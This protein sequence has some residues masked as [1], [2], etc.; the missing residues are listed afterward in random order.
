MKL[1]PKYPNG[2][3]QCYVCHEKQNITM[4]LE[5]YSTKR[6]HEQGK[7]LMPHATSKQMNAGC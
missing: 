1:A 6:I 3:K 7:Q 2:N 5:C 4:K